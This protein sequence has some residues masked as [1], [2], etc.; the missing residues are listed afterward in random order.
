MAELVNQ[1]GVGETVALHQLVEQLNQTDPT[2]LS[3]A[4]YNNLVAQ[5]SDAI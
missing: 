2:T 4:E 1:E 3:E 5:A